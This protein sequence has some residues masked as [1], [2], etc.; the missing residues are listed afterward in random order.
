[1]ISHSAIPSL[2]VKAWLHLF[3]REPMGIHKNRALTIRTT[4]VGD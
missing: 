3:E 2:R 4:A 1:M